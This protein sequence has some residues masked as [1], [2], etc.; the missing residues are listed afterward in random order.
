MAA[1]GPVSPRSPLQGDAIDSSDPPATIDAERTNRRLDADFISNL[2]KDEL[3]LMIELLWHAS[4]AREPQP[5]RLDLERMQ[6]KHHAVALGLEC[7]ECVFHEVALASRGDL[8]AE[9]DVHSRG[10]LTGCFV[11]AESQ[12]PATRGLERRD[13]HVGIGDFE[14]PPLVG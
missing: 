13:D 7:A 10:G 14:Q 9:C 3:P 2:S 5:D 1:S 12:A 4:E 6:V 8:R 11:D